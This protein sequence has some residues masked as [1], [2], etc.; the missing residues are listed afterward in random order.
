VHGSADHTP[1]LPELPVRRFALVPLD[2]ALRLG[3]LSVD[4]LEEMIDRLPRNDRRR[5]LLETVGRV[6]LLDAGFSLQTQETVLPARR[7][8]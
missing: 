8:G 7:A 5:N 6:D 4:D 3:R 1:G 2:S